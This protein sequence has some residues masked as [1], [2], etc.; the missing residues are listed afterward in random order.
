MSIVILGAGKI[1]S[2]VASTLSSEGFNVVVIDQCEKAIH[3]VERESDVATILGIAP[4]LKLFQELSEQ[5]PKI[6]FGATSDDETNIVSCTIAKNLGI[7]KTVCRLQS[8]EYLT[9]AQID[10][11]SIFDIDYFISPEVLAAEDLCKILIH[12]S[13]LA[14]EHF[15]HGAIHMRTIQ[16][17]EV[18]N[19]GDTPIRKLSLPNDL[20]AGLIR[21]KTE[22]GEAV[23]I[24]HGND[25]ILPGDHLTVVGRAKTMHDLDQI[26]K[27]PNADI[28]SVIIVGGSATSVHLA[29]FLLAN[30]INVRLIDKDLARCETLASILPKATIINR[31]GKDPQLLRSERVQDADAF[32]SC[33]H[34][35]ETNLMIASLAKEIGSPKA[36]AQI[37][38]H[39]IT[40]ILEKVGVLPA[41]SPR[42]GVANRILTILDEETTLSVKSLNQDAIK[43]VE[44]KVPSLS[45]I[46][47]IPL[48]ELNLPKG[49]LI[50]AI[51]R[52]GNVVIGRGSHVL[53][54]DDIVIA[55]CNP[56]QVPKLQELFH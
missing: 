16:I 20:I 47:G 18:W 53:Q 55:I 36:I 39:Q 13:D 19:K 32:V 22:S 50:A 35:D 49:L 30:K 2:Y 38:N 37:T 56:I 7:P 27:A 24:P 10:F 54:P 11:S 8:K 42:V 14:V 6:F 41:F 48:A 45:K 46:S 51:E 26:F 15:A 21:R 28:H 23:L 17:P 9:Q 31:D 1:G 25:Y 12:S 4:N 44:L 33:T 34:F 3:R 40:P 5:K 43:I 29:A 52:K